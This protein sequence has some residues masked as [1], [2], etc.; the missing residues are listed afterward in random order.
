M[1]SID[2]SR[3]I[4]D[5]FEAFHAPFYRH[6][7]RAKIIREINDTLQGRSDMSVNMLLSAI[8]E[9]CG[10]EY[11]IK[12]EIVQEKIKAFQVQKALRG[13]SYTR[14]GNQEYQYKHGYVL[15]PFYHKPPPMSAQKFIVCRIFRFVPCPF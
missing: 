4:A 1:S 2:I 6:M 3:Q 5:L 12:Y 7:D 11:A 15:M 14:I 13:R 10:P 8:K 9:T